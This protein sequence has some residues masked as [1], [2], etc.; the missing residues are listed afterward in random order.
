MSHCSSS[1]ALPPPLPPVQQPL[2][3]TAPRQ[4]PPAAN[5]A[6]GVAALSPASA[7]PNR[8]NNLNLSA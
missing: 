6:P 3:Q 8:G 2:P 1:S 7:D 4:T 5:G